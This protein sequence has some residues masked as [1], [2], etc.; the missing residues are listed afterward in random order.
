MDKDFNADKTFSKEQLTE[1]IL[2]TAP[3]EVITAIRRLFHY[4]ECL[5]TQ[6]N[7]SDLVISKK[8]E[9]ISALT[10]QNAEANEVIEA[11]LSIEKELKKEIDY[12]AGRALY[13]KQIAEQLQNKY[14]NRREKI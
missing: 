14:E 9:E 12:Q 13:W 8:T 7:T 6:L 3:T 5:E 2:T 1:W 11:H 10:L 4:A